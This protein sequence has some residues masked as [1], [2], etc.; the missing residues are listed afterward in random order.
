MRQLEIR[1]KHVFTLLAFFTIV[2]VV[3]E[4][5]E[6]LA[7]QKFNDKVQGFMDASGKTNR[8][9]AQD[10]IDLERRLETKIFRVQAKQNAHLEHS[11][12]YTQLIID[13]EKDIQRLEAELDKLQ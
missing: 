13:L 6:Y 8:F 9:T 10:G 11:A 2:W 7:G 5:R 12:K 3:S 1:P 4:V